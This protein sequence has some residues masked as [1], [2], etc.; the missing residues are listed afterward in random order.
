[1][2][3]RMRVLVKKFAHSALAVA[4]IDI[5]GQIYQSTAS[6]LPNFQLEKSG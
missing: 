2:L 4:I 6:K 5:L 1:M 3:C